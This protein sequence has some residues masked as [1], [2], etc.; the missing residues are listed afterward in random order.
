MKKVVFCDLKPYACCENSIVYFLFQV[1]P[2]LSSRGRVGPVIYKILPRNL[3][4]PGNEPGTSGS[5]V[6]NCDH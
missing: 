6:R 5:V 4:V 2:Q 1:A 3:V